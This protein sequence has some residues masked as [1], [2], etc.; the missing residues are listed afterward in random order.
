MK[1]SLIALAFGTFALGVA[2]FSMMG[3]LSDIAS[4]MNVSIARAGNLISAYAAGV[5]VGAP[6][7]LILRRYELQRTLLFL[8][9]MI[10]VTNI[11][12]ALSTNFYMMLASRFLAGLPHGAFFGVGAI[13]ASR[14]VPPG[15]GAEAVAVMVGGMNIANLIGVPTITWLGSI[16]TWRIGFGIAALAGGVAAC[17]IKAWLPEVPPTS[18]G[19]LK[20]Q[21]AFLKRGAPWLIIGGTFFGQASIYCWYSYMEPVMTQ[22]AGFSADSMGLVMVVAGLGMTV[23]GLVAGRLA[24][25]FSSALIAGLAAAAGLVTLPL[26]YF[27]VADK[28]AALTLTFFATAGLFAIGGPLQYII[29]KFSKGGEMLGGAC[30]QIAFNMSNAVAAAVGGWFI[31]HNYGINSPALVGIPF[32]VVAS[33]MLFTL[34]ARYR[35]EGA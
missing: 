31:H 35:R 14:I 12:V 30:I 33:V 5:A 21:F 6:C 26:I 15:R 4:S 19:P 34:Y 9:V 22:I 28:I 32:A 29:V 16:A 25:R 17:C 24:D 13:V 27:F 2:E 23:G 3:L 7:L 10:C 1:K 8:A 20:S 11:G 18:P